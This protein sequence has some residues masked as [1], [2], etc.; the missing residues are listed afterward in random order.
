MHMIWD[1][2]FNLDQAE[3]LSILWFLPNTRHTTLLPVYREVLF[4]VM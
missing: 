1:M 2:R 3:I 4:R